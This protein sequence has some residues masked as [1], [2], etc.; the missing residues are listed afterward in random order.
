V[1]E[2]DD[3]CAICVHAMTDVL[4]G[5]ERVHAT[6]SIRRRTA[7][8]TEPELNLVILGKTTSGVI[9]WTPFSSMLIRIFIYKCCRF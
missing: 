2:E 7:M 5:E 8:V 6:H 3:A 9:I 4:A 1:Q